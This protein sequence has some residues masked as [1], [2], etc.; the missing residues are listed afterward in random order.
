MG[1]SY[2][3]PRLYFGGTHR[4]CLCCNPQVYDCQPQSVYASMSV[5]GGSVRVRVVIECE[6]SSVRLR[7]VVEC[8]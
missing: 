1:V 2:S 8:E 6:G 5:E 7:M 3:P 4:I